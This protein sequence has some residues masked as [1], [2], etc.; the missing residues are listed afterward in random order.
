MKALAIVLILLTQ[1]QVPMISWTFEDIGLSDIL[2]ENTLK[3]YTVSTNFHSELVGSVTFNVKVYANV[4]LKLRITINDVTKELNANENVT[5]DGVLKTTNTLE[6]TIPPQL[7]SRPVIIYKNST[8][9][10]KLKIPSGSESQIQ[11]HKEILRYAFWILVLVPPLI[12]YLYE[13]K[14]AKIGTEGKEVILT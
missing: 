9:V 1:V 5:F 2:I 3:E 14:T 13:K 6:I 12:V 4:S 10:A 7:P 8:I 11:E